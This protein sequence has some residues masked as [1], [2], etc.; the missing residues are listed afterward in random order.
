MMTTPDPT[1]LPVRAG[2]PPAT[3]PTNPHT[4]LDQ[5][6]PADLQD[7]L[8]DHALSLP[9]VRLSLIHI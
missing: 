4:Q 1:A 9:G 2:S 6:A 8:R 3:T 7:R 5:I